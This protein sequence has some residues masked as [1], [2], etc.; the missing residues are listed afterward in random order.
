MSPDASSSALLVAEGVCKVYRTG[1]SEVV[2]VRHLDL[3]VQAGQ[4]V[5][6]MGPSGSGRPSC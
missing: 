5:A 3:R 1:A 6:V 2:A 4:F